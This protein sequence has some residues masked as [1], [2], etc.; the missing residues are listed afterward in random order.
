MDQFPPISM[1]GTVS[2]RSRGYEQQEIHFWENEWKEA[3]RKF[4]FHENSVEMT[5]DSIH[6][7]TNN[8]M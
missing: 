7:S 2:D 4:S 1:L 6:S 8:S 5:I 3:E